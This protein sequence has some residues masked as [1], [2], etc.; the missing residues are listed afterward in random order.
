MKLTTLLHSAEEWTKLLS[1]PLY[2]LVAWHLIIHKNNMIFT[3]PVLCKNTYLYT[4]KNTKMLVNATEDNGLQNIP[5]GPAKCMTLRIFYRPLSL[6]IPIKYFDFCDYC[7]QLSKPTSSSALY[8]TS[9]Q[10][11]SIAYY[12]VFFH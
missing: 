1:L 12:H 6:K 10:L 2:T 11:W 5:S 9:P 3:L 8:Q 4:T 7:H